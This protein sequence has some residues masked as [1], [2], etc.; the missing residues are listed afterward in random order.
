M[1]GP[2]INLGI[3]FPAGQ[4][5]WTT[6]TNVGDLSGLAIGPKGSPQVA[7]SRIVEAGGP[8]RIWLASVAPGA[9]A[10]P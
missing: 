5:A 4:L 6:V 10:S 8:S 9:S 1:Y 3:G 7:F 2:V